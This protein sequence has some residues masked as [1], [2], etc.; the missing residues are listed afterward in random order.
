MP[1]FEHAPSLLVPVG[2]AN[3]EAWTSRYGHGCVATAAWLDCRPES[4]IQSNNCVEIQILLGAT[5][6][7]WDDEV[8]TPVWY[9]K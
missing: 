7:T 4:N 1:V 3:S 6:T 9:W 8:T 2:K 5:I